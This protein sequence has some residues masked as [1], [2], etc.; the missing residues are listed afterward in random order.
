[1]VCVCG[2]IMVQDE[3]SS[4]ITHRPGR[5]GDPCDPQAKAYASGGAAG[6]PYLGLLQLLGQSLV[7]RPLLAAVRLQIP[8]DAN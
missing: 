6:V 5:R 4:G 1:M 7:L 2:G 3:Q 8:E